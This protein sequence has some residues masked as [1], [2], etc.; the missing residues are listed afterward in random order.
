MTSFDI[1]CIPSIHCNERAR[2]VYTGGISPWHPGHLRGHYLLN[3]SSSSPARMPIFAPTSNY[4]LLRMR[5][6]GQHLVVSTIHMRACTTC[7][8]SSPRLVQVDLY[9]NGN[10]EPG[11]LPLDLWHVVVYTSL[12]SGVCGIRS[13]PTT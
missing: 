12:K 7:I 1:I 2:T 9:N 5:K 4:L 11:P 10:S 13:H 8:A 6:Y 3:V